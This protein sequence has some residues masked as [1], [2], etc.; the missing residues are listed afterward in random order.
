MT[1]DLAGMWEGAVPAR[2]VTSVEFLKAVR[3]RLDALLA[4]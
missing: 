2:S 1:K 3:T 4:D